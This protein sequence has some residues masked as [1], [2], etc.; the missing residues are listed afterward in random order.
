MDSHSRESVFGNE[1]MTTNLAAGTDYLSAITIQSLADIG[2]TV[3]L[4]EADR[5]ILPERSSASA[6]AADGR[7]AIDLSDDV[8]SGPAVFYDRQGRVV[9]VL[10]N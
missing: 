7:Q 5:F 3:N 10:R 9:R 2:Y 4:E 1:L 6:S 8:V